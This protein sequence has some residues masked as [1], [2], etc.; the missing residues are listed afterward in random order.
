M[1]NT[2]RPYDATSLRI[3]GEVQTGVSRA[4]EG[5]YETHGR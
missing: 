3:Q 1:T 5:W 4:L 2:I